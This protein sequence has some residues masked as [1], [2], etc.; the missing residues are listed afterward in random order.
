MSYKPA[1]CRKCKVCVDR[2]DIHLNHKHQLHC[3]SDNFYKEVDTSKK[4]TVDFDKQLF[5]SPSKDNSESI[6]NNEETK[7][8]PQEKV[9]MS[10]KG[11][12]QKLLRILQALQRVKKKMKLVN[13]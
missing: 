2:I 3:R 8:Q 4:H 9:K 13:K 7:K 5:L 10:Q 6:D 11:Y 1:I 12:S